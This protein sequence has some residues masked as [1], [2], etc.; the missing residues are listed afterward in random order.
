MIRSSRLSGPILLVFLSAAITGCGENTQ[1]EN[2]PLLETAAVQDVGTL[3]RMFMTER[4]KPP[5]QVSDFRHYQEMA[6]SGYN[7][8]KTGSIEVMWGVELTDLA[9]EGS[10]DSPDEI[11]AYEKKVPTEGGVVLMK[12]RTTRAMTAE[13]FK[14]APK[15]QGKDQAKNKGK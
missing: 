1:T 13:E 5:T 7:G 6:P 10:K 11:L 2:I 15:A 3:Y 12:N 8:V 14:N 9:E 4:R